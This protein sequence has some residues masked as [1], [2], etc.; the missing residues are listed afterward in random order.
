MNSYS[1]GF[2]VRGL[3]CN[4][5]AITITFFLIPGATGLIVGHPLDSVKVVQQTQST[6][7][8]A[9]TRQIYRAGGIYGESLLMLNHQPAK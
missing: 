9:T 8:L 1:V 2:R 3:F 7:I 6:R 4:A 5:Q